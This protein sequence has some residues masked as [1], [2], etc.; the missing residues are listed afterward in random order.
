MPAPGKPDPAF[1]DGGKVDLTVGIRDAVR[2][3]NFTARRPLVAGNVVVVGSSIQD[4]VLKKEEPPGYVHGFDVRTGKR[5]WT[6]HTIPRA[7]EFGYDTWLDE[8]GRIHREHERVGRRRLRPGAR[9]HLPCDVDAHQ[10]LLRRPS[11]GEQPVRRKPRLP[12]GE[13]RQARV[14]LPGRPSRHLG[15]RLPHASDPRRHHGQR[16][17][18]QGRHADQQAGLHLRRSTGGRASRSGRSKS[19]RCRPPPSRASARR[20]RSRFRRSRR[21][22]IC[23]ARPKTTSSTSRRS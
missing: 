4:Q 19:G 18:D 3:M 16:P 5:V 11:P 8:L 10:Q 2:A 21:R 23:R 6:F 17:P 20:R 9:L 22:S 1:G 15:L 14:A 7:G 12:R 13:D